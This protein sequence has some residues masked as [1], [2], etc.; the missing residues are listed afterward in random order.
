MQP[1]VFYKFGQAACVSVMLTHPCSA[2]RSAVLHSPVLD[3]SRNI[4][5]IPTC[6][7]LGLLCFQ[8]INHS[9]SE[10]I[11]GNTY[12]S[13]MYIYLKTGSLQRLWLS[14]LGGEISIWW[15]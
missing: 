3:S 8:R 6:F 4:A 7:V 13:S 15:A 5:Y 12:I 9:K 2:A 1:V 10:E 14:K 11:L